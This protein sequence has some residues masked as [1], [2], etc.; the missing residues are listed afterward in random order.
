[1]LETENIVEGSDNGKK[2]RVIVAIHLAVLQQMVG[3]NSVIAYGAAI[4]Q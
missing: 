1:M 3:I 2:V 4:A